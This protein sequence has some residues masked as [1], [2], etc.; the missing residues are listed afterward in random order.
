MHPD[1]RRRRRRHA[2]ALGIALTSLLAFIWP[3]YTLAARIEPYL[4]GLP[5]A[6]AWLVLWIL[7]CFATF[8]WLYLIESRESGEP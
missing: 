6:L 7:A 2:V 8:L 5:F 1:E 3:G 4:L